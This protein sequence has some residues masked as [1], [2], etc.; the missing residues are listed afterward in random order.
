[1]KK[2]VLRLRKAMSN[3]Q[4]SLR[5]NP[6]YKGYEFLLDDKLFMT[7]VYGRTEIYNMIRFA[8]FCIHH[9]NQHELVTRQK[10]VLKQIHNL[11]GCLG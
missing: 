1:M 10:A 9:I 5:Y 7:G 11:A 2:A 8:E 3:E 4:I 6:S